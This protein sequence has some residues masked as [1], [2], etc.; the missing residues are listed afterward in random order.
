MIAKYTFQ[1]ALPSLALAERIYRDVL[2]EAPDPFEALHAL[3]VLAAQRRDF[4]R[5][6]ALLQ[7][8][9]RPTDAEIRRELAPHLCRCGTHMRILRAVRRAAGM[10]QVADAGDR[11]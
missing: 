4:S 10:M 3:G 6:Q 5:A 7:G 8:N 2:A 1:A 11:R 9:A